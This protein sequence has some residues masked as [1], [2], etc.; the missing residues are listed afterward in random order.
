MPVQRE[1]ISPLLSSKTI[2]V[3]ADVVGLSA[4]RPLPSERAVTGTSGERPSEP[5]GTPAPAPTASAPDQ[6]GSL[7]AITLSRTIRCVVPA[8]SAHSTATVA[9]LRA[10][11][12]GSVDAADDP[13]VGVG[14]PGWRRHRWPSRHRP[15]RRTR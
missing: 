6:S 10:G 9:V 4:L 13:V 15:G 2:A 11:E 8:R 12:G 1:T 5:R 3:F 14:P 7:R